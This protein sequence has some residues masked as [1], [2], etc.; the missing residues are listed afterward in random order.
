LFVNTS[1][2]EMSWSRE[3]RGQVS[4]GFFLN[5]FLAVIA[6]ALGWVRISGCLAGVLVGTLIYGFQGWRG[7]VLLFTFF[8]LG[9]LATKLGYRQVAGLIGNFMDSFLG[10]TLEGKPGVDNETVNFLNT[11]TGAGVGMALWWGTG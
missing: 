10:A 5:A 4:L 6:W 1:L 11:F 8:L 9:S 3:F 7:F 2:L